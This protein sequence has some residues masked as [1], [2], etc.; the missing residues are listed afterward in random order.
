MIRLIEE[1][2]S[3]VTSRDGN[4]EENDFNEV[5]KMIQKGQKFHNWKIEFLLKVAQKFPK[6]SGI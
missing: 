4:L 5:S 6:N 2:R 3:K 1:M